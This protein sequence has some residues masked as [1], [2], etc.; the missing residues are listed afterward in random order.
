MRH[1]NPCTRG[2]AAQEMPYLERMQLLILTTI[3]C[4]EDCVRDVQE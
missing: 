4:G 3:E 1:K 2:S